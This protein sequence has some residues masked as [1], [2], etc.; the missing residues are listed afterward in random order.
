M[1]NMNNDYHDAP[2]VPKASRTILESK[3]LAKAL[4]LGMQKTPWISEFSAKRIAQSMQFSMLEKQPRLIKDF[5]SLTAVEDRSPRGLSRGLFEAFR[6][7][8]MRIRKGKIASAAFLIALC[9]LLLVPSVLAAASFSVTQIACPPSEQKVGAGFSCTLTIRNNGDAP[10]TIS[11]VT[12]YPDANN[13]LEQANY[14]KTVNSQ[15]VGV[16]DNVEVTFVGL[17]ATKAGSGKFSE[18]RIDEASD[19][20]STVTGFSIN[21]ID[22]SVSV[23]SSKSSGATGD[24]FIADAE[25]TAGGDIDVTLSFAIDSGGCSISNQDS[26]KTLNDMTHNSKQSRSWTVTMGS[27]GDCKYTI[28][29]SATGN[30]NVATESDSQ[31]KTVTC[32]NCLTDS[33]S[34][35][36]G[37][38]AGGGGGS[39]AA[40]L[41]ELTE[42]VTTAL[43]ANEKVTFLLGGKNHSVLLRNFTATTAEIEVRSHPQSATLNL[44]QTKNF[45]V[46]HNG[47]D[48]LAVKLYGINVLT[49]K[50]TLV[51]TSLVTQAAS[52]KAAA[53]K[54]AAEEEQAAGPGE[55]G[56]EG[57]AGGGIG[58]L[59]SGKSGAIGVVIAVVVLGLVLY[60]FWYRHSP[61][62]KLR[63]LQRRVTWKAKK[64]LSEP[65]VEMRKKERRS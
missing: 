40:T 39:V 44:G 17:K 37:G 28:T 6:H 14:P 27:S 56:R 26:Q 52:G 36:G 16:G 62:R 59:L 3:G 7:Q 20:S 48:D 51:L 50:V 32:T 1:M 11:T 22:V 38:G 21:I 31:Q 45:D 4:V 9:T 57:G 2:P 15:N 65:Y 60:Y 49:K 58:E 46:D 33:G 34:S 54:K 53:D 41:G 64:G 18:V 10:G 42:S 30:G 23:S 35:S 29:A 5:Q 61:E 43:G 47:K 25:V 24:T 8:E 12:L 63:D 13:W 55:A 19:T